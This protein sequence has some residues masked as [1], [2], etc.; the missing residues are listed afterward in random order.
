VIWFHRAAETATGVGPEAG[1]VEAV[2]LVALGPVEMALEVLPGLLGV[3]EPSGVQLAALRGLA[4]LPDGRVGPLLVERWRS[5]GPAVRREA[6][7]ALLS[8]RERIA[9]LL[10]GL[11]SGAVPAA[12]L[13][14]SRRSQLLAHADPAVRERAA[15]LLG[16]AAR[17]A[18]AAVVEAYRPA[19]T[20]AGDVASGRVVYERACATCHRAEGKG[21]AVGPDLATVAGRTPD[22]LL[23]HI[24]DPNREVQPAYV[25]YGLATRDGQV[26]TGLI[27]DESAG[28]VTLKR[29]EGVTDVVPRVRID[30]LESSG[31][32]LMP[33][34]LEEQVTVDQMADLIA[35]LRGLEGT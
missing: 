21:V 28:S 30:E 35:F 19:T 15:R 4:G 13:D 29:A 11:E 5:L 16:G 31:Q 9:A 32:S 23:V 24:L 7:E 14:P 27:A 33:E 17:P 18:R 1:R 6:A 26:L 3:R 10:D 20:R 12:D 34:G 8:R 25:Q 22:D 2:E